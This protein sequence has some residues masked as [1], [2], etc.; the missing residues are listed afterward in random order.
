MARAK[1]LAA[2]TAFVC[3]VDGR[4]VQVAQGSRVLASDPIVKG[5]EELFE[6]VE[7]KPDLD[8]A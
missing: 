6:P 7:A 1:V 5:R 2:R 4:E 3:E 8:A